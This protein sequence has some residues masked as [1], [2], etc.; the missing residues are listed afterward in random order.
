[1]KRFYKDAGYEACANGFSI[2]LDG[3]PVKTPAKASLVAPTEKM[4]RHIC[5]EWLL[6][7]DVV[8]HRKMP[9]TRFLNSTIDAITSRR[10]AVVDELAA[11]GQTDLLCYRAESPHDLVQAESIY[12]DPPLHWLFEEH[13]IRLQ[14]TKGVTPLRQDEHALTALNNLVQSLDDCRLAG[15]HTATT[16]SGSVV[17]GLARVMDAI[18]T[19]T[20]WAAAMVNEDHQSAFW[21]E[22]PEEKKRRENLRSE[23]TDLEYWLSLL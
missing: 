14:T 5:D 17:L 22:D 11:F 3:R 13:G 10:S 4:A 19:D 8:D 20:L 18:D 15:L 16:I 2:H 7:D 6:M 21:G 9:I 12:W 23:L 1:M